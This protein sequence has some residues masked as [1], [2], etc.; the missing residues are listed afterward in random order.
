MRRRSNG[1]RS[2]TAQVGTPGAWGSG[3]RESRPP[4]CGRRVGGR[5]IR[6]PSPAV[7]RKAGPGEPIE[8]VSAHLGKGSWSCERPSLGEAA[9]GR[10]PMAGTYSST[11]K[12][13]EDL[14][15]AP[16]MGPRDSCRSLRPLVLQVQ[17][18][19]LNSSAQQHREAAWW[20]Y[21]GSM[22]S[23]HNSGTWRE[24]RCCPGTEVAEPLL[25]LP[26]P[27]RTGEVPWTEETWPDQL[28]K[29]AGGRRQP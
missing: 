14:C 15:W 11:L 12:T 19:A 10:L 2:V 27:A 25:A 3:R 9:P 22:N 4:S 29:G 13:L 21:S 17:L 26:A 20:C 7:P 1:D 16:G 18:K 8:L 24:T 23:R 6:P 28:R 5:A